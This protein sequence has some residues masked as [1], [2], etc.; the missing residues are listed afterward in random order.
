MTEP[1]SRGRWKPGES[2]NPKGKP[3]GCGELQKLRAAIGEHVPDIIKKLVTAAKEGD[4]QA[5]RLLLDR[6]LP[7][8]KAIEPAQAVAMAGATLTQ[9]GEAV[10]SAVAAGDLA[11]S[12]G[13]ALLSAIATLGKVVEIDDL[14]TRV[15]ALEK[16]NEKR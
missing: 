11:P 12:Q 1:K 6:V 4:V 5:A 9:K 7:P 16:K 15:A 3:A 2:G 8:L 14:A 13:A 10:L